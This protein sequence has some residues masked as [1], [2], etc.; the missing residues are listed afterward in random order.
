MCRCRS[1]HRLRAL[2]SAAGVTQRVE[3]RRGKRGSTGVK[4]RPERVQH[5]LE[6]G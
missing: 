3:E 5:N 6:C 4:R 1:G 2:S